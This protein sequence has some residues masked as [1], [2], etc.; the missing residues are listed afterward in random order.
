MIEENLEGT[1][2]GYN[3]EA[4]KIM[5]NIIN[6]SIQ[7]SIDPKNGAIFYSNKSKDDNIKFFLYPYTDISKSEDERLMEARKG[8]ARRKSEKN[9]LDEKIDEEKENNELQKDKVYELLVVMNDSGRLV[10]D[11]SDI[12]FLHYFR[13][14][15]SVIKRIH[16]TDENS[17]IEDN[18]YSSTLTP[19]KGLT[20]E[21]H[22]SVV[23]AP[24]IRHNI[25]KETTTIIQWGIM[26][27]YEQEV[28]KQTI[29]SKSK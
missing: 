9:N 17:K 4:K 29:I 23:I 28:T 21:P 25:M 22:Y 26:S 5:D 18:R 24:I 11:E 8:K 6:E 27:K 16:N 15:T 20:T 19:E 10:C 14:P 12:L 2:Q 1:V 7:V 13:M 3:E